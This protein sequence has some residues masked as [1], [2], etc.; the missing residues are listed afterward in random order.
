MSSEQ[1]MIFQICLPLIPRFPSQAKTLI[2]K[3][4]SNFIPLEIMSSNIAV[5]TSDHLP[6]FLFVS[7]ILRNP[8]YQKSFDKN[9]PDLLQIK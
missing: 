4:F 8:S 5:I 2:N 9:W 7:N 6:Q 1:L 3:I